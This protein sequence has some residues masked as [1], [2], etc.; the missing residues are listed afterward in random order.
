[1]KKK[2][3]SN[4]MIVSSNVLSTLGGTATACCTGPGLLACTSACAPTCGTV[5]F[6]FFGLSSSA[7][8]SWMSDYWYAFLIFSFLSFGVAFYKLFIEKNCSSSRRSKI[9][10]VSSFT[11]SAILVMKSILSC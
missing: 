2:R 5:G 4:K 9:V 8:A 1:M 7:F 6:S 3:K 10:F 11:L